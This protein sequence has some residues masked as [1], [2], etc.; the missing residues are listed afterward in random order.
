[1]TLAIARQMVA[2][3]ILRLRRNRGVMAFA[4]L[5]TV[6]VTVIYFGVGA[7]EHASNPIRNPPVGGLHGFTDGI[8]ALGVF[9]GMLSAILIGS[10]A[11]TSDRTS[12]VFR[13]LV[14]TG[15]S[16]LALFAV[17]LPAAVCVSLAVAAAAFAL[18]VLG[19]FL[20]AGGAPV[21]SA[22]MILRGAGW[23]ALTQ[24]VIVA[25]AV[26]VGSLTGSRAVT[27][28]AVI[29]WQAIATNILLNVSFLGTARE[30]LLT[31]ALMQI[32]PVPVGRQEV[33]MATGVA[34]AVLVAWAV[35]PTLVGAWRTRTQDA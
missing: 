20:F 3:E 35:V 16:R 27:L 30:G 1:M 19:T 23:V 29:G 11:G 32:I 26:G 17:R 7:I 28:T 24:A 22:G 18:I 14:V 8:R 4:L 21:P 15:R 25:F 31:P 34:V 5:L 12:G 2:A 13:D 6:G 9:F 10:E 33:T